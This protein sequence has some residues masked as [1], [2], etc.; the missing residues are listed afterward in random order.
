MTASDT[1]DGTLFR[2]IERKPVPQTFPASTL[3]SFATAVLSAVGASRANA[4]VVAGSLVESDLRGHDSHGVRRLVPYAALAR[5]GTLQVTAEPRVLADTPPAV[6]VVDGRNTFGQLTARTATRELIRRVEQTGIAV[7]VL[8]QC[9]HVG[10]LRIH[11]PDGTSSRADPSIIF[12]GVLLSAPC[13][14]AT[15]T[16][17]VF[18]PRRWGS[19]H[20]W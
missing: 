18:A 6:A 9:Q 3:N 15:V 19:W 11:K 5:A 2:L 4:E 8:R 13:G 10:R 12:D 16:R 7:A 14:P 1:V 20:P 17:T